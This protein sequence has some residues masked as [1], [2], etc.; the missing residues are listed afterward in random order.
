MTR[1]NC[2]PVEWLSNQHLMAEYRELPRIFTEM[3]RRSGAVGLTEIP[4]SYRLGTGHVKFFYNKL[5]YLYNRYIC[6]YNELIKR[7]YNI[8]HDI[9]Q[10]VLSSA[11]TF[12]GTWLWNDWRPCASDLRV[13][14]ARLVERDRAHYQSI[15]DNLEKDHEDSHPTEA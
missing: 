3:R 13:N 15:L 12:L 1:I 14:L 8:D 2:I 4:V 10:S 11:T 9:Y 7:G 5:L 6:I